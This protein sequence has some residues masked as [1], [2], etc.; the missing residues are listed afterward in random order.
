MCRGGGWAASLDHCYG[1]TACEYAERSTVSV[2]C[3]ATAFPA[4]GTE[5]RVDIIHPDRRPDVGLDDRACRDRRSWVG[6][7]SGL[8]SLLRLIFHNMELEACHVKRILLDC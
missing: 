2:S 4:N 5:R 6:R 8:V 7:R 3:C 1:T